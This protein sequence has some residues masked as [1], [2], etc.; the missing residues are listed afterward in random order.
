MAR[1]RTELVA[2]QKLPGI[3]E[4]IH[5]TEFIPQP[6]DWQS[7]GATHRAD[8]ARLGDLTA[9]GVLWDVEVVGAMRR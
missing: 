8:I 5:D 6:D 7:L 4:K 3:P 9:D 2:V 1:L